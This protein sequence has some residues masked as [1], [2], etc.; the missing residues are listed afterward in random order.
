MNSHTALHQS[1][2]ILLKITMASV[3]NTTIENSHNRDTKYHPSLPAI[4]GLTV[5]FVISMFLVFLFLF[6][7]ENLPFRHAFTDSVITV[8]LYAAIGTMLP[9]SSRFIEFSKGKLINFFLTHLVA[10]FIVSAFWLWLDYVVLSTLIHDVEYREFLS[11]SLAWRFT[12]SVLIYFLAQSF[13][14][15]FL[16]Y[17]S[18]IE[19]A[20]RESEL[21]SLVTQAELKSLKFQI[22][23]HFIFNSL[24]SISA[25][26]SLDPA[27]AREMTIMLAD[28]LRST[29]S[30]N[31]KQLTSLKEELKSAELYVGIEKI[32]FGDKFSFVTE[33]DDALL[34][35]KVPNMILQPLIENAVKYSVYESLSTVEIN[36]TAKRKNEF[37][38]ISVKNNY[39]SD[40]STNDVKGAGV[41]LSNIKSRLTLIYDNEN[42]MKIVK[43]EGY[44]TVYLYIPMDK[45]LIS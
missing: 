10:A 36:I 40:I 2:F 45:S 5:L 7:G 19:K 20:T 32:R 26:T 12:V 18:F 44:F 11:S 25:L 29:L 3:M 24:N 33:V 39:D 41:G 28:F 37:L 6:L 38:E 8:G 22:N 23:P 15:L 42:L 43:E 31:I 35:L 13:I 14:Y 27:K 1:H 21:K 17:D 16:F 4:S 30:N 9:Y 34:D